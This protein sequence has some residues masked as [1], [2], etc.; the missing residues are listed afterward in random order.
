MAFP[1]LRNQD[2]TYSTEASASV[3][4][5]FYSNIHFEPNSGCWLWAGALH[6]AF[7]YGAFKIGNRQS[8]VDKAHRVS[9]ELHKG[10]IPKGLVIRHVCDN[11]ACVNPNHLEIGTVKQNA[12]DMVRRQR[13]MFGEKHYQAK[14]TEALVKEMRGCTSRSDGIR[15]GTNYGISRQSANDIMSKRTWKHVQ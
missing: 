8:K 11:P 2:G 3:K 13:H 5:R 4:D 1:R 9:Y 15:I 10:P 7:G 6:G 12:Q 14:A